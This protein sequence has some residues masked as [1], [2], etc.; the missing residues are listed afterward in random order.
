MA[1][2]G[3]KDLVTMTAVYHGSPDKLTQIR[4]EIFK[5]CFPGSALIRVSGLAVPGL[6]VEIRRGRGEIAA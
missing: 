1:A 6:L 3:L 5:E 2:Q 4:K